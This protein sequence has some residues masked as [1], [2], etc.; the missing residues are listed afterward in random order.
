VHDT[1]VGR[2]SEI[3]LGNADGEIRIAALAEVRSGEGFPE[4]V[5][6][7]GTVLDTGAALVPE[8]VSG[9]ERPPEPP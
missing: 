8:L 4:E 6:E 3:L 9:A 5:L 1:R 7:L 2:G